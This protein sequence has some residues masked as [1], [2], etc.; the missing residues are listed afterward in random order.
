MDIHNLKIKNWNTLKYLESVRFGQLMIISKLLFVN[1]KL[2][3]HR[4]LREIP[5]SLEGCRFWYW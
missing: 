3:G 4:A 1:L 2:K 5:L